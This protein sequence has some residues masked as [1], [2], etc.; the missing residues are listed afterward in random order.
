MVNLVLTCG[1]LITQVNTFYSHRNDPKTPLEEQIKAFDE[2]LR[3][4][5]IRAVRL[6]S[7]GT[8]S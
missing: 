6:S 4:G 3:E 5:K 2:Q 1:T 7:L 8:I